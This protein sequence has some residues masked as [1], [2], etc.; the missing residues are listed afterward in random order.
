MRDDPHPVAPVRGTDGTSRYNDR[1][2]GV[3]PCFQRRYDVIEA[4]R[5]DSSRILKQAPTGPDVFDDPQSIAP[6][7]AVICRA[8]SLPGNT[9]RLARW[10]S[11]QESWP[12]KGC[13]V[14]LLDVTVSDHLRPVFGE[15]RLTVR[16]NFDLPQH[17][18]PSAGQS[19][20]HAADP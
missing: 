15:Y 5:D 11:D 19:D 7:P 1:P 3:T 9:N 6:E 20:V 10:S 8:L 12:G 13:C 2:T 17:P 4:H 18:K 16:I 14:N